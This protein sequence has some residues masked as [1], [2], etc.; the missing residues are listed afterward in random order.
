[1][2]SC[3]PMVLL[4]DAAC[5]MRVNVAGCPLSSYAANPILPLPSYPWKGFTTLQLS[6]SHERVVLE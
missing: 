6:M 3:P 4:A 2:I 5:D 1:M